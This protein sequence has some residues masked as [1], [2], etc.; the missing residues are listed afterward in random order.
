VD[1]QFIVG[2]DV[3]KGRLDVNVQP[4]NESFAVIYENVRS[5]NGSLGS[6]TKW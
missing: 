6:G 4:T 5:S 1:Q 2:V 3:S